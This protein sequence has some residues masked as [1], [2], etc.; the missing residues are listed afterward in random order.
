MDFKFSILLL[1]FILT[2]C[3]NNCDEIY[4][5]ARLISYKV[6]KS[7]TFWFEDVNTH[8]KYFVND[9]GGRYEPTI[10]LGDTIDVKYCSN[11]IIIDKDKYSKKSNMK[12]PFRKE[13]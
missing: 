9:F 2:S 7:S 4:S 13:L 8:N 6:D 10:N 3:I 11:K 12:K 1:I 5:Q